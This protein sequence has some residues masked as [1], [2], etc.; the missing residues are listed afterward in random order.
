MTR[1]LRIIF[2]AA[3]VAKFLT[4]LACCFFFQIPDA[5]HFSGCV[6]VELL[7]LLFCVVAV[8]CS[9]RRVVGVEVS[10]VLV[11]FAEMP[12]DQGRVPVFEKAGQRMK[13]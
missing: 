1:I 2:V 4:L 7:P 6:N 8:C 9:V 10:S 3:S 13:S 5:V 12:V 11:M